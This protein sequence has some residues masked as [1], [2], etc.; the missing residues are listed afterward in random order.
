MHIY[1]HTYIYMYIFTYAHTHIYTYVY[2]HTYTNCFLFIP[3]Y[4]IRG[5]W[6]HWLSASKHLYLA[7]WFLLLSSAKH[8][9][10]VIYLMIIWGHGRLR[11]VWRPQL[12]ALLIAS[13]LSSSPI[14]PFPRAVNQWGNRHN[15]HLR[16]SDF[17]HLPSGTAFPSGKGGRRDWLPGAQSTDSHQSG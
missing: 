1:V 9:T 16:S 10:E 7:S 8:S 14:N 4:A 6:V 5:S 11:K 12:I 15:L 13:P 17:Q 2:T 3:K